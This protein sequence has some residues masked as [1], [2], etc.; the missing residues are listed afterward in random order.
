MRTLRTYHLGRVE[1]DDGLS[2]MRLA[3]GAVQAGA[4]P[5]TD[6]LFL[7]EHPPVV[8][9]GRSADRQNILAAPAWLESQGFEVHETDREGTSPTTALA[10]W[11]AIRCWISPIAPTCAGTWAPWRRR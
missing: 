6:F 1:Y 8:T 3:A 2:L 4:P 7:L 9:L 5:S 10:R 11:S